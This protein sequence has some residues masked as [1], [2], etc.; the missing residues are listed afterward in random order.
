[1]PLLSIRGNRSTR[2][3][4]VPA[5]GSRPL[6]AERS[7]TAAVRLL[8]PGKRRFRPSSRRG[9]AHASLVPPA[10]RDDRWHRDEGHRSR[11]HAGPACRVPAPRGRRQGGAAFSVPLARKLET[12]GFLA[13][14]ASE[15]GLWFNTC[16]CKD[17]RVR[18]SGRVFASCRNVLFL[19]R[20][21]AGPTRTGARP[22]PGAAALAGPRVARPA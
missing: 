17:L 9:H 3:R 14:V 16:G 13:E 5:N 4:S 7:H 12:Y 22:G 1:M 10:A 19:K 6:A 18:E 20:P 15:R 8:E 11:A 21:E 2:T